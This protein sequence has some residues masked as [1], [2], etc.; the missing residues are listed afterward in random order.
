MKNIFAVLLALACSAGNAWSADTVGL[1]GRTIHVVVGFAA[2]GGADLSA[3]LVTKKMSQ[4]TG[5]NFV[6]ENRGGAGGIVATEVVAR[7]K[8]DGNTLLWGSIGA[9]ALSPAIGIKEPFDPLNDFAP[10]SETVTLCNVMVSSAKSPIKSVQDLIEQARANPGKLSYGT[11]GIGSAGDTSGLLLLKLANLNMIH[12]PFKGGSEVA[13][14]LF[15]GDITVGFVTAST[16]QTLGKNRMTA[17]AVTSDKRDPTLPGVPTFAEAGV[18]GYDA[19]F[20]YGL[21]APKGTPQPIVDALNAA[22]RQALADPG[23]QQTNAQLGVVAAPD[24]SSQFAALIRRDNH[25]WT[26]LMSQR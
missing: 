13:S 26:Q 14:N 11:P 23:V 2:G 1:R 16:V 8:P 6:I 24:S 25:R 5:A 15:V 17:L 22:V 9:F 7:A 4:I 20:W 12:V 19:T 10:I 3:R 18:P 21:L